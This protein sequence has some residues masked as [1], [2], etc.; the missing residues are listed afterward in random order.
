MIVVYVVDTRADVSDPSARREWGRIED[1]TVLTDRTDAVTV[2]YDLTFPEYVEHLNQTLSEPLTDPVAVLDRADTPPVIARVPAT[3]GDRVLDTTDLGLLATA[4]DLT[5]AERD[6]LNRYERV[7]TERGPVRIK[8]RDVLERYRTLALYRRRDTDED[9]DGWGYDRIGTYDLIDRRV[10]G[11]DRATA[12]VIA[13]LIV[14]L[15]D[16]VAVLDRYR[17][18]RGIVATVVDGETGDEIDDP[19]TLRD[20]LNRG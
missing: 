4:G 2:R 10:T 3:E 6:Q 13:D 5:P 16:P 17:M 15:D 9:A 18:G 20:A 11:G 1:G 8:R 12:D 7:D 19:A 14:P